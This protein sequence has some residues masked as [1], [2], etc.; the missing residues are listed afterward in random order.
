M[1]AWLCFAEFYGNPV[2][3]IYLYEKNFLYNFNIAIIIHYIL[4]LAYFH[5]GLAATFNSEKIAKEITGLRMQGDSRAGI[6]FLGR[7]AAAALS[8]GR[9]SIR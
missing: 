6:R 4:C 3:Q 5:A 8:E 7:G 2:T 9:G 1:P